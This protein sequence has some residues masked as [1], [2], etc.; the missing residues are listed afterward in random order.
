M[1][2]FQM[3]CISFVVTSKSGGLKDSWNLAL[4][5]KK[6]LDEQDEIFFGIK[7]QTLV[8]WKITNNSMENEELLLCGKGGTVALLK[9]KSSGQ[10][11]RG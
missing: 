1:M 8:I 9:R 4:D 7:E 3:I 2:A 5:Y 10:P 11:L 6:D